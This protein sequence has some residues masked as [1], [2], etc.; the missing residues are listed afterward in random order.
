[1]DLSHI[2]TVSV[3]RDSEK[4]LS[5]QIS[6]Y[7]FKRIE[8]IH[9]FITLQDRTIIFLWLRKKLQRIF[10]SAAVSAVASSNK[11]LQLFGNHSING[12]L[13]SSSFSSDQWNDQRT[14]ALHSFSVFDRLPSQL[15]RTKS[16]PVF[17]TNHIERKRQSEFALRHSFIKCKPR[18]TWSRLRRRHFL[19]SC[20]NSYNNIRLERFYSF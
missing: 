5:Y 17:Q 3:S 4:W 10:T 9:W 8:T 7:F 19:F 11:K 12:L 14:K 2:Q 13:N 6:G 18:V 16:P 20:I 1:M 15:H